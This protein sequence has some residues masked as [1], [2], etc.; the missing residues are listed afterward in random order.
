MK[1]STKFLEPGAE[2]ISY[3]SYMGQGDMVTSRLSHSAGALS[4]TTGWDCDGSKSRR[5][6][7]ASWSLIT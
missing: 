6:V 7:L 2:Y 3:I 5:L 4:L 1:C